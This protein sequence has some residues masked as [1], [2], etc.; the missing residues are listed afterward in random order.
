MATAAGNLAL[1]DDLKGSADALAD[2]VL[3]LAP[4]SGPVRSG[5]LQPNSFSCFSVYHLLHLLLTLPP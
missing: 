4:V 1:E 3:E 2:A 5:F